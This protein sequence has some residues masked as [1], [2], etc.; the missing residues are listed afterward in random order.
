MSKHK[1]SYILDEQMLFSDAKTTLA[2]QIRE[3]L[4]ET[5]RLLRK[6]VEAQEEPKAKG[7]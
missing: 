2:H 6:L 5:N 4:K 3:E 7:K 1:P